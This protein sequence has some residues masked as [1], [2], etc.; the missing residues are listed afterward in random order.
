MK[1]RFVWIFQALLFSGFLS[2]T[3]AA[4]HV[5]LVTSKPKQQEILD[6]AP[7]QVVLTFIGEVEDNHNT[8]MVTDSSNGRIDRNDLSITAGP[9]NQ[10]I[11][12]IAI[13]N[14]MWKIKRGGKKGIKC[15]V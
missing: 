3:P 13:R 6:Q 5:F 9:N 2:G 11:L 7:T 12:T 10:T 15:R 8:V 1:K 14:E 4:A